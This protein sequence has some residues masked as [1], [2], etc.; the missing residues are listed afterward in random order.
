MDGPAISIDR[1]L[2]EA[3]RRFRRG[4]LFER[5][6]PKG[7]AM[8][9]LAC[10]ALTMNFAVAAFGQGTINFANT[11]TTLVYTNTDLGF[12]VAQSGMSPRLALYYNRRVRRPERGF[13]RPQLR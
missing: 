7:E 2:Q 8:R 4:E 9:K 6:Q 10:I 1:K 3:Q 13:G 12:G 5:Q 11:S